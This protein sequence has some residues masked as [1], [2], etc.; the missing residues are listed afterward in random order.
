MRWFSTVCLPFK[1]VVAV[2]KNLPATIQNANKF[3]KGALKLLKSRSAVLNPSVQQ[4]SFL[5][6][7]ALL[8]LL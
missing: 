4:A 1:Y 2:E 5:P 8:I 6:M 3:V 7:A